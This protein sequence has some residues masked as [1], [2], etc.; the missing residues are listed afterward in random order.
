MSIDGKPLAKRK[1]SRMTRFARLRP[2]ACLTM[3]FATTMP[4]RA[5]PRALGRAMSR[6]GPR[7]KRT[8]G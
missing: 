8:L 5:T 1:D 6:S 2:T 7:L 3:R 4:R